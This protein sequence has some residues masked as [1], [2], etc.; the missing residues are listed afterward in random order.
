MLNISN[1]KK[2]FLLIN[3]L[4]KDKNSVSVTLTGSYSEHF[5]VEKAGDIDIIIICK[6]LNKSYFNKC[7]K[8][9]KKIKNNLFGKKKKLI[10]NS[11]FGPIKFYEKNS[12][13]FHLMIYDINGHIDHTIKSPFTC[14]DWERSNIYAGKRL[15]EICA[16]RNLQLRDFYE[17]RRSTN[18]YLIDILN[19]KISYR[20]YNFKG[21]NYYIKKKNYTIDEINKRDF[22]YHT[23][24]FLLINYIKYEKNKN[25]LIKKKNVDK[26]FLEITKSK[27]LLKSFKE[28]RKYKQNKSEENIINPKNLAI[29]F[30][31]C[32]DKFIQNK[33]K[34]INYLYFSRHKK[35]QLNKGIFLGQ[36]NNPEIIDSKITKEFRALK[37]DKYFS[38]P[39]KRCLQT[40]K[41]LNSNLKIN[42]SKNLLEIDYGDAENLSFNSF[43]NKYPNIVRKW[44]LG[45][46][47]AF[48][49][50]ETTMDVLVRL[51]KFINKELIKSNINPGKKIII[52]THNVVL[53]CLI[54]SYFNIEMKDWFKIN[55]KYFDCYEFILDN[56]NIRTNINRE[57][58]L[59]LFK[60][61]A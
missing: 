60:F 41:L 14:F 44:N 61:F 53:R 33:I 27:K 54:G 38:S 29:K 57:K 31:K 21:N 24:N 9:L 25:Y 43:K 15:K 18:E 36:K 16:V 2:A 55:I 42:I 40:I 13:V 47:V 19:N 4:H 46:D 49:N 59:D 5:N 3:E 6:K 37:F 20:E 30:I 1:K 56:K 52:I 32:F 11:T 39:S 26:K 10:I 28:L 12:I 50:G 45:Q 34:S 23:I 35:T 58:F 48:P 17:A 7:I 22:I 51:K 8:K